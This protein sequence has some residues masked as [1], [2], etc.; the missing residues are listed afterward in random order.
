[1][2]FTKLIPLIAL[3]L[4]LVLRVNA[5]ICLQSYTVISGD[6]CNAI[7][8]KF[9]VT[10]SAIISANPVINSGCTNLQIGQ[11]LCIL[12][13]SC[14]QSYTVISG[15]MCNAIAAKFGVTASAIISANPA[16]NS[17]CTNLQIGQ[18]LC[19]PGGSC[20]QSYTVISG[21]TCNAIAAKFGVTAAAI[22][23]ENPAINSGCTNLQIGQV[24]CIPGGY[25]SSG[26][27]RL[28]AFLGNWQ[29]CPSDAQIAKYTHIVVAFAVT[30]IYQE[31]KNICD[32]SCTIGAPVPV[33]NNAPNNN[34]MASWRAAG[35]KVI[36]SFGGAGMGGSWDG[37]NNCWDYCFDKVDSVITQLTSIVKNQGFDGV[38][39]DYEYFYSTTQQQ[40]FIS[41]VTTGLR[42]A[43][44]A[45][46]IVT[47]AP[48]DSDLVA[49]KGYYE[50][51]RS[52]SASLSFLM[53]Q[54]YNGITRPALDGIAGQGA[55]QTSA[56]SHY[57]NLVK[58]MF[59][60]DPTKVVFGFCLSDCSDSNVNAQQAVKIMNDLKSFYPCNGG[61]FFWVAEHD[62]SASWSTPVSQVIQSST[63]CPN[64]PKPLMKP[65]SK[66]VTVPKPMPK[67]VPV[68]PTKPKPSKPV[69]K[70]SK[71]VPKP[72]KP[73]PKPVNRP[74]QTPKKTP[75]KLPVLSPSRKTCS[76]IEEQTDYTGNDICNACPSSLTAEGCCSICAA[77]NNCGAFTWT[78]Y[79]GGTCWLKTGKTSTASCTGCRSA[80]LGLPIPNWESCTKGVGACADNWQCCV[81]PADCATGKTT[82]RPG[83]SECSTCGGD[84]GFIGWFNQPWTSIPWPVPYGTPNANVATAFSG[85]NDLGECLKNSAAINSGFPGTKFITI[86]VGNANGRWSQSVITK[87]ISDING[88]KV[89]SEYKGIRIDIEEGDSGL[90]SYFS[91]LFS[92][93]KAKGLQVFVTVSG[94]APYGIPDK[95]N[96]MQYGILSNSNINFLVPQLYSI[97]DAF[98]G[99]AN[100][101]GWSMWKNTKIPIVPVIWR[102]LYKDD[103]QYLDAW[104]KTN[105][106]SLSGYMVWTPN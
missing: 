8:A 19:I 57:T 64:L 29:K 14:S 75:V 91:S 36:L 16:I 35:K 79:N 13:G 105:G 21:D 17:G 7:A 18:I 53:P 45:G 11:V 48:M 49:G 41:K 65:V 58:N 71:P 32:E 85:W 31:P 55:G 68:K 74:V 81:A 60:G 56:L 52:V 40:N 39:I 38:D 78:N 80:I 92:A 27:R 24:L 99:G 23:S 50:V 86:G 51:L 82:C 44:P 69:P 84:G 43:L 12:G 103:P 37:L 94:N 63:G 2:V 72:A 10:A 90:S 104:A 5:Q 77:T 97:E 73:A 62:S 46:S 83:G 54:Y 15:D 87:L 66:P 93:A 101:C 6:T 4:G 26:E 33:C 61:A 100:D 9:G 28:I 25:S 22:I 3:A 88:Y 59:N 98:E 89:P 47:H 76:S 96:L 102:K 67:L 70:P 106:F 1:M 42:A 30:Y 20:A 95:C 34:L